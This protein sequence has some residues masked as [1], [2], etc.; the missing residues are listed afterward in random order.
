MRIRFFI[1]G[2]G[3]K[4]HSLAFRYRGACGD[5]GPARP[6]AIRTRSLKCLTA[7]R[8]IFNWYSRAQTF[9]S[10][11]CSLRS[12]PATA[13]CAGELIPVAAQRGREVM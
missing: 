8:L 12:S 13:R 9:G 3:V 5:L 4:L 1:N 2:V 11:R 6:R 7:R 10:Y